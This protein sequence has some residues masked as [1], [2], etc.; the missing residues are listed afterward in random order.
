M[1]FAWAILLGFAISNFASLIYE[2][3]W[4]RELTYIFGT[5]VY[6]VSTILTSFMAGLALGSYIFGKLA[7]RYENPVKLFA[8]LEIGIG[9]Y[10]VGTL[11]IFP[12]LRYPFFF[13]HDLFEGTFLFSLS[14]FLLCFF[15]LLP[16]TAL[17]GGTFPLVGKIYA[18]GIA[19]LGKRV[20]VVYTAD[21]LGA[22]MG[23]FLTGFIFLP[24]LGLKNT[25]F[26]AA[27]INLLL[28]IAIY[29]FS[30]LRGGEAAE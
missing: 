10:G 17:I 9:T 4:S 2:V 30:S 6:A 13:F 11:A 26:A 14:K 1:R 8:L 18:S 3:A 5:S 25:I 19:T 27:A 16:P 29:N 21:T 22:A 15:V 28:G 24:Y 20:G 23:S 12:F 7:D